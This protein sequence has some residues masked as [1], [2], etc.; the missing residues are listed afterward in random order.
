[1]RRSFAAWHFRESVSVVETRYRVRGGSRFKPSS[2]F[3]PS[4]SGL[5]A[6]KRP[7]ARPAR[8]PPSQPTIG[9]AL[10]MDDSRLRLEIIATNP[11]QTVIL[12][13]RCCQCSEFTACV[14]RSCCSSC[15]PVR[16]SGRDNSGRVP[17]VSRPCAEDGIRSSGAL[18]LILLHYGLVDEIRSS[19]DYRGRPP[20]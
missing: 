8:I 15:M 7:R 20:P 14:L 11:D 1:M 9:T 4:A 2:V 12:C 6:E 10:A 16:K 3:A 18:S 5:E 13:P 19:Q 17:E